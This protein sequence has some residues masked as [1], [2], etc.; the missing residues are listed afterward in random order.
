[1]SLGD[2]RV[3]VNS[4]TS[5]YGV[6][7]ERQR[8]RGTAAHNTVVVDG[9]DSSEVWAGFRVARRAQVKLH[10]VTTTPLAVAVAASHDGYRRLPGRNEHRRRFI[11]DERSLVIEDEITGSFT[12][13]AAY[14]HL[15]PDIDARVEGATVLLKGC[16][17][18][19]LRIEFVGASTLE[20]SSS[21][22]HPRF[23]ATAANRCIVALFAGAKLATRT[24][25]APAP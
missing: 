6:G 9:K 13:A 16:D 15:H 22:W 24:L 14:F 11:L 21:T 12:T 5:Q 19:S 23:G 10:S 8:Q 20:C 7:A 2:R 17:G 25:W 3:F 1:L 4:G 18:L